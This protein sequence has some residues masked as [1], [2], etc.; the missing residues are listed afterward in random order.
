MILTLNLLVLSANNIANS[1]GPRPGPPKLLG[2]IW[3]QTV[4]H[5]DE[6]PER[7]FFKKLI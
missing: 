7:I 1:F 4:R 5:F 6:I 3:Y 2:L